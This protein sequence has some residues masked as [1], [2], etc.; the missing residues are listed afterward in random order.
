MLPKWSDEEMRQLVIAEKE[1]YTFSD[2]FR[3]NLEIEDVLAYFGYSFQVQSCVLPTAPVDQK[4]IQ[5]LGARLEEGLPY[6]SLT[7]EIAR[8][9]FLIAPVLLEVVHYTHAKLKVELA[10][11]VNDQLKGTLDYYL[12]SGNNLL[13]VEAK[14]GDMQNGFTQLAVELVALD[15]WEEENQSALYGAVSMGNVWQFGFL[16]RETKQVTQDYN[17]YRVPADLAELLGILVGILKR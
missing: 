17:L 6:V 1:S 10:V 8:R 16:N 3:L 15:Q 9:E 2:Y 4:R 11:Q 5:T 14:K 12:Q 13:V 7:T